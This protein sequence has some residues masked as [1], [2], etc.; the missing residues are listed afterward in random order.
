MYVALTWSVWI[1]RHHLGFVLM[2]ALGEVWD[3]LLAF[4]L[5]DL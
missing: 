4:S 5:A 2:H 1:L 3:L